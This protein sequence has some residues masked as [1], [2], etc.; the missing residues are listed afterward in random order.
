MSAGEP[1]L[2]D[3]VVPEHG[4]CQHFGTS[5]KSHSG[6]G[7]SVG[8]ADRLVSMRMNASAASILKC[9]HIFESCLR[10]GPKSGSIEASRIDLAKSFC[11]ME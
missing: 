6:L 11:H 4:R 3:S 9:L 2:C 8:H 5:L 7:H 10:G 1:A